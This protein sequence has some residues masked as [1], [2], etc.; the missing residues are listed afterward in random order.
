MTR[1]FCLFF[2]SCL[3][4]NSTHSLAE[5][6][7]I[8]TDPTYQLKAFHIFRIRKQI[9]KEQYKALSMRRDKTFSSPFELNKAIENATLSRSLLVDR[10]II[11]QLN[12][13]AIGDTGFIGFEFVRDNFVSLYFF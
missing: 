12:T 5:I 9:T 7:W 13:L 2:L 10:Q 3:I 4:I 11:E 6:H 8:T 1:Y